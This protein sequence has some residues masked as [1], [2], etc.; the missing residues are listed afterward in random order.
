[1]PGYYIQI[2]A[3]SIYDWLEDQ[4]VKAGEVLDHTAGNQF[5]KR[6]VE[7]GDFVY[8]V[9][10]KN[11]QLYLIGRMKVDRICSEAEARQ[12][13]GTGRLWEPDLWRSPDGSPARDH[14]IAVPGTAIP[15]RDNL[16][17]PTRIA[18]ELTFITKQGPKKLGPVSAQ[19]FQTLR[20]L[21]SGSAQALDRLLKP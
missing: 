16:I 5:S 17:V 6:G 2:W 19:K 8:V 10:V 1:M 20:K 9:V 13:I 12:Y 7:R 11:K 3:Q 18:E 4:Y 21:T 15:M 14:L